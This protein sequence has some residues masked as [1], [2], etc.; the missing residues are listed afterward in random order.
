MFEATFHSSKSY[1]D[2]FNQLELDVLFENDEGRIWRVPAFWRGG[3]SWT[4]RFRPDAA[5]EFTCRLACTDSSNPDLNGHSRRIL[6]KPYAGD[7]ALLRHGGLRVSESRRHFEHADGTPFFWLGDTWWTGLSDRLTWEGFQRL[8]K[9]RG[10]KGFTLIQIVAGLVPTEEEIPLDPGCCNEGGSVWEEGFTRIN[11][12]YFDHADRRIRHLID[13]ELVPAIVGGWREAVGKMGVARMK[14]HWRYLIER[15][16]AYPVCWVAGGEVFDPSLETRQ[17]KPESLFN[18]TYPGWTEVAR[19]I[20]ELDPFRHPLS[21]HEMPPPKD[22]PVADESLMD[23]DLIQPSH[24]GWSSLAVAV[25]QIGQHYARTS[26]RKPIVQ[27]ELGYEQI[28]GGHLADFQRAAF[29]LSML[30][31]A[32]GHTYGAEGVYEAYTGDKP[33]HRFRH[34]F[35]TWEEG[36]H[37]PGSN[38]VSLNAALLKRYRW[39]QF[40][41]RPDWVAPRGT[42]FLEPNDRICGHDFGDF[43]PT[44]FDNNEPDALFSTYPAGLWRERDGNFYKPYAAGVEREV[45]I[46][47]Y[48]SFGRLY[49]PVPPTVLQLEDGVEYRAFLWEPSLG[50]QFDLGRVRKPA[51]GKPLLEEGFSA[52]GIPGWRLMGDLPAVLEAGALR[53]SGTTSSI[54]EGIDALDDVVASVDISGK[55]DAGLPLRYKDDLNYVAALF[56][57]PTNEL[58]ILKR[59]G[60]SADHIVGRSPIGD[61]T[62]NVRLSAEVRGNKAIVSVTDGRTSCSSAIVDIASAAGGFC[63]LLTRGESAVRFSNFALRASPVLCEDDDLDRCLRDAGGGLRGQLEGPDL[64]IGA[65]TRPGWSRFG[66]DKHILLN[67]YRPE[68]F[69][70]AG[71]WVLV[72][73]AG[74][75]RD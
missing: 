73:D 47:Y 41:P 69:P 66:R 70:T 58:L 36:M 67:A 29:W 60:G 18:Q 22:Y 52:A 14:Q 30:N 12:Q 21:V 43:L 51:P 49:A 54:F 55:G 72:L 53:A 5:G 34:S 64:V 16:G 39:W 19:Y 68:R 74:T 17:N 6:V 40:E 23:F 4:V 31:G 11:P 10:E 27:G 28:G 48:P 56:S 32:A 20:R 38:Q 44:R 2:P 1:D 75:R 46:I 13:S 25:A 62:G 50:I 61:I 7:N 33:L 26:V 35:L 8:A 24:F 3:L 57:Q 65:D 71:D 15:Y 37:L 59:A 45:R 9:D 42:T 63:G